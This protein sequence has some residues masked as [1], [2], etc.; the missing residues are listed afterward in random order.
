MFSRSRKVRAINMDAWDDIEARDALSYAIARW[1]RQSIQQND[2]GNLNIHMTS[3][4]GKIF[5][6]FRAFMLVS[7]AKQFWHNI[8]RNDF[9]AYSAMMWSCFYGGA[10]YTLQTHVNAIGRD[11]KEEF[12]RERLSAEEIGKAAF[13]RSSW[14][15]LLP[16]S[17]D[18]LMWATGQEPVFAYKRTTG[19][20]TSFIAGNPTFDLLD[21]AGK[22]AR[23]GARAAFN[24]EYQWSRGQQR[25]LNSLLPFQNAIGIKNVL[26][27]MVEGLPEQARIQ[28]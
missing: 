21:T 22:V 12:L 11:D 20:A 27:T 5:T 16:G 10:A 8:K 25:A 23:G 4:M 14:A 1:T 13:Q 28:D 2:V 6:Q 19:L 3:T 26:N 15:S 24:E 9:A 18:T 7:Y 17:W